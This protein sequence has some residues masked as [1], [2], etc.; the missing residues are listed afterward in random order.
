MGTQQILLIV[1]SVI[2]VGIAVAVG[3]TM[4]AKQSESSNRNEVIADLQKFG[5]CAILFYKTPAS[6]AG[7][8]KGNP[9]FGTTTAQTVNGVC[10]WCGFGSN[11]IFN[12]DNGTYLFSYNSDP[13]SG[14]IYGVGKQKGQNPDFVNVWIAPG[15]G[16]IQIILYVRPEAADP[17]TWNI[18]N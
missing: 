16:K 3:I 13:K 12:N 4:F 9:G 11:R 15:T 1:L 2:I 6:M 17:F 7:G 8:G 18:Q 5:S 14:I 10:R